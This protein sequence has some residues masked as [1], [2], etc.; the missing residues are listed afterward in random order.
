MI[1]NSPLKYDKNDRSVENKKER[2]VQ[3]L[4]EKEERYAWENFIKGDDQS[5]I[6]IY[7][8]YADVLYQY[9][10]Q[11]SKREVFVQDCI[12]DLF[13]E[14]IEKRDRLGKANSVKGY[15]FSSLKRKIIRQLKK[16]D[17]IQLEEGFTFVFE[18][19]A[20]PIELKEEDLVIVHQMIN[21]LPS[22]QRE[23]IFLYFYQGFSYADIAEVMGIKVGS[24]RILTYRALDNLKSS[25]GPH[26]DKFYF[27]LL[28]LERL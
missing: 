3:V 15:L 24:A 14:L 9:G 26:L 25:L 1:V 19:P 28:F 23:V 21:K 13:I 6:S 27:F 12:Q 11:F 5:L 7:R 22:S 10:Q 20:I 16:E 8:K 17:K 2:S 4:N 18:L